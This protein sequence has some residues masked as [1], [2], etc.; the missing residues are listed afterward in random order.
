MSET[1]SVH[2]QRLDQDAIDILRTLNEHGPLTTSEV[3]SRFQHKNNDYTRRRLEW[4]ENANL[5]ELEKVPWS[6]NEEISVNQASINDT[7]V[8][9]LE[10]WNLDGVGEGLPVE[11]RVRRLEDRVEEL[12]EENQRLRMGLI[13]VERYLEQKANASLEKYSPEQ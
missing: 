1:V 12:E 5:V 7:G 3:R 6:K 11:E 13:A 10:S 4:L 2:E 8:E 9:F